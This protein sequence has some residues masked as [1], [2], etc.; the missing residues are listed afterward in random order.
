MADRIANKNRKI[1]FINDQ[2]RWEF[3][4]VLT[5]LLID[6]IGRKQRKIKA[7]EIRK[8]RQ[9]KQRQSSLRKV[10]RHSKVILQNSKASQSKPRQPLSLLGSQPRPV[11]NV[12]DEKMPPWS[13][14]SQTIDSMSNGVGKRT[15]KI[16]STAS[17]LSKKSKPKNKENTLYETEEG[18]MYPS[19]SS[20]KSSSN[21]TE[22]YT[23]FRSR[24]ASKKKVDYRRAN[25]RGL[26]SHASF[27]I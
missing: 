3:N 24:R 17:T 21:Q 5:W 11:I 2:Y 7:F 6:I 15:I 12:E 13:P 22:N 26:D 8:R 23:D 1:F 27:R 14:E 20:S 10:P 16:P 4:Y 19:F 18:L 9:V 25:D